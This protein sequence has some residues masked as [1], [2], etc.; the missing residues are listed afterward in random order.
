MS[1]SVKL[2]TRLR[3]IKNLNSIFNALQVITLARIQKVRGRHK[4]SKRYLA[5][6]REMADH[7][8]LSKFS[9]TPKGGKTLAV[10]FSGNRGFCGAFNQNLRYRAQNFIKEAK[11]EVEF[12]V[13]G[14]KGLEFLRSRK[15]KIAKS[16]LEEEYDFRFFLQLAKEIIAGYE[17]DEI[18]EFHVIF[19]R[20]HSVLRQD[21]L[22]RQLMPY[23][24]DQPPITDYYILELDKE[25]VAD[26]LFEQ[27]VAARLYFNCLDSQLGELSARM[28]T[29]KGAIENSKELIGS[30]TLN[31]NKERQ[32]SITQELL[33]IISSSES[34]KEA[35]Y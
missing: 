28:F 14:R 6:I 10:L 31:L 18:S 19:N 33:E 25:L 23:T 22:T 24:A 13:F 4:N 21:A 7:I 11:T 1:I 20:F 3:T 29:L 12:L 27:L 32:Q 26:K 34:L 17:S 30:L 9:K 15:Q 8:D 2:K 16:F 5:E 35:K